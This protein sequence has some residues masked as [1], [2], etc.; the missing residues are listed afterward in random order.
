[1]LLNREGVHHDVVPHFPQR[2]GK[3]YTRQIEHFAR[4]LLTG[5]APTITPQDARAALQNGLAAT[6]SQRDGRVVY[7]RD[8]TE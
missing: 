1:L 2:F 3:A 5:R 7:V 8:V 6:R 4:C